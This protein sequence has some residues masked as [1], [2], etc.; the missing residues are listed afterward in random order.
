MKG[1][2]AVL[3]GREGYEIRRDVLEE[4]LRSR[5]SLIADGIACFLRRHYE[6]RVLEVV[7]E[8]AQGGKLLRGVLAVLICEA[9]GAPPGEA[10][11]AAVAVELAHAA[12][13]VHDDVLDADQER[14]GHPAFHVHHDVA[15]AILVPHLLVPHAV[16]SARVYGPAA[17]DAILEGWARVVEGQVQDYRPLYA[18][19]G[20]GGDDVD[21]AEEYWSIV[22][23]KT[24]ALFATAAVLGA[25]AARDEEHLLLARRYGTW[26]GWA[27]QVADD[28][29]DL[30]RGVRQPWAAF[31]GDGRAAT[32]RSLHL[33][34][35]FITR[36]GEPL[37]T[38]AAIA[39]T[40]R[41]ASFNLKRC[42]VVAWAFPAS[43]VRDLLR[44]FPAL[45]VEQIYA[46]QE[47]PLQPAQPTGSRSQSGGA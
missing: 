3:A 5:R 20:A 34:S 22:D 29:T 10:L 16:L 41:L 44:A 28:V 24:G 37:I 13:L 4:Y 17:I 46:E 14:R 30:E 7:G 18:A 19:G 12:S 36:G 9:L 35:Q 26:L 32:A 38:R 31:L 11:A 27:F 39:R 15:T 21:P 45:A 43:A 42:A 40:R 1:G 23:K 25:M 8:V 33:L 47:G 6:G 2:T